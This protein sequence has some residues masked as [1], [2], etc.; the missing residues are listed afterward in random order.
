MGF[1]IH[2]LGFT[3]AFVPAAHSRVIVSWCG[4]NG[5]DHQVTGTWRSVGQ[6]DQP[7]DTR[8]VRIGLDDGREFVIPFGAINVVEILSQEI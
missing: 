3:D 7:L 2:R 8:P 5:N 4:D 6:A 1:R